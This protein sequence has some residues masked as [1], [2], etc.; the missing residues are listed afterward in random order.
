[1]LLTTQ[2]SKGLVAVGRQI[3]AIPNLVDDNYDQ[4]LN[5]L[6][7]GGFR[8]V[9][10][11]ELKQAFM[12]PTDET[13]LPVVWHESRYAMLWLALELSAKNLEHRSPHLQMSVRKALSER[14]IA[15]AREQLRPVDQVKVIAHKASTS[16]DTSV[17]PD[18]RP[19]D[20]KL[21]DDPEIFLV[22]VQSRRALQIEGII[23][24]KD[25]VAKNEMEI[26]RVPRIG[27]KSLEH[28]K[29]FLAQLGLYLG[30]Q[31]E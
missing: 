22:P 11:T 7:I 30:M 26:R 24:F 19:W 23:T 15:E 12:I 28:V 31:I 25:L 2:S 8:Q 3:D 20:T 21:E 18:G 16:S 10:V 13:K 1:V 17:M 29:E 4:I 27:R 5:R 6:I 9:T 14:L